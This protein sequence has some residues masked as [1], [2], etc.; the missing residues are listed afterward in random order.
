M[1]VKRGLSKD[2]VDSR[3]EEYGENKLVGKKE[4][5]KLRMFFDQFKDFLVVILIVASIISLVLG[6]I[7]DGAII[8]AIVVLNAILGVYQENRANNAIKALKAMSSP[9]AKVIRDGNIEKVDSTN[10]VPGDL[11]I[12]ESGDY[13][14]CDLILTE[15]MNLKIDESALTGESVAVDKVA[16]AVVP[17]EAPIGDRVDRA[18]M[19]TI[20]TYGRGRGIAKE[21]GMATQIG[22]IATMLS[23]NDE[24]A[25]PLQKKL[26]AFGKLLGIVCLVVCATIFVIG[27]IRG[28]EVLE[29]FMT[30]VSL[31]VAA[32]PEGLTVVVTVILAMGMQRMAKHNTIVKRL[33][34]VETLGST[35]VI[36]SDKTGTLTQ[37]EMTVVELY[38]N[39]D[40]WVVSGTGYLANGD[41]KRA[42]GSNEGTEA[43][44]KLIISA[45]LCNDANY[46][47]SESKMIGDPT[48]GALLVLG[49]K[50]GFDKETLDDE[51]PRENEVPFDSK[52]KLMSTINR[53]SE[54]TIVFT[55]GA[56]DE[57][58]KRATH[59][60]VGNQKVELT[61]EERCNLMNVNEEYAHKALRVLGFAYRECD[62]VLEKDPEHD[63]IYLGLVGMI[64]PP[65]KEVK[66]AVAICKGAGIHPIMI[67]GD[68]R[69]TASAIGIELGIIEDESQALNGRDLD[70]MSDEELQ[71]TV[72][73]VSVYA[74]V[75][76]EHKVRLVDA[77]RANGDIAAMT[78]DGVNDAPAINRADIGIAM[79][80]TGTDVTKE[81]SDMILT[82]DN[83]A[84]I[85][86]A[87]EEGRIIYSNVRK[88]IA[89]LLSSNVGEILIVFVAILLGL[90]IP[91][92]PIHLLFINLVT[93]AFPAFALGM[94]KKEDDIMSIPPRNPKEPIVEKKMGT[95]IIIQSVSVAVAVLGS[96]IYAL[97]HFAGLENV[98]VYAQT[99]CFITLVFDELIRS[100]SNRSET[101]SLF[102]MKP[103]GNKFLNI[104]VISSLAVSL[105][106]IYVPFLQGIFK[107]TALSFLDLDIAILFALIPFTV[108]EII[109]LISGRKKS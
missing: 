13:V 66:D 44:R 102:K 59:I 45:M 55:K 98:L 39:R 46:K 75:S 16:G 3:L 28:E 58:L 10:I 40:K 37:N 99:Y 84:S 63:L 41:I 103:F 25:T 95:S 78:G 79:G 89:Y 91:L 26:D 30:A 86:E 19:S 27:L 49:A 9:K 5:T 77:V 47:A 50:V 1:D 31:A 81:A 42:D 67:T 54:G 94:E 15:S 109:K 29:I 90:P 57:V 18:Y 100:Y 82:D 35:T 69:I 14:P 8:L 11:V 104:C 51:N 61:E 101:V 62:D 80:I 36:C 33:S 70:D 21:T 17:D 71:R 48:E 83:F 96:F 22:K 97:N 60:L 23:E 38:D 85:V 20:V 92:A 108:R 34:A 2:E 106:V 87:V 65:R 53:T 73:E 93:D 24:E 68:H 6:E 64:D 105:M 76:P 88:V 12:L 107:T 52:R 32:I 72:K 7:V 43:I 4:R 56:P 74:R